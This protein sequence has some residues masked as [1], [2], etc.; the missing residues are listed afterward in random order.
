MRLTLCLVLWTMSFLLASNGSAPAQMANPVGVMVP[1][2]A[3]DPDVEKIEELTKAVESFRQR[4]NDQALEALK[5]ACKA[6]D[7]LPPARLMLARLHLAANQRPLARAN[8]EQAVVD[9]PSYPSTYFTLGALAIQE[10]RWTDAQLQFEKGAALAKGD[11]W[12]AGQKKFFQVQYHGGLSAVAEGRRDWPTVRTAL[13]AVLD[14]EPKNVRFRQGLARALVFLDKPEQALQE[15]DKAAK[16]DKN[17]QPTALIMGQF[18]IQKGDRKK[19]DEWLEKAVKDAPEDWRTH[20]G[21]ANWLLQQSKIEDAKGHA[22]TAGRLKADT[23]E[24]NLLRGVIARY[25][26]DYPLAEK[27]FQELHKQAPENFQARNQLA[28]A[29]AE[30]PDKEKRG[31][32]LQLAALNANANPSSVEALSTLGWVYYKL[33]RLDEAER[34]LTTA[35]S[36]GTMTAETAY[37]LA[38]VMSDRGRFDNAR[39]LLKAAVDAPGNFPHRKDAQD[40]L[41]RITKKP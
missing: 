41:E 27:Y 37:Y 10:T 17:P 21:L 8:L 20:V 19:A 9:S 40:W 32:A 22:E 35:A 11:Q 1:E 14:L 34:A 7:K 29:L 30:Q 28:L 38:H 6:H 24:L 2:L 5:A 31:Q 18:Y 3:G 15:L 39:A 12:T 26:K 16:E 23:K 33:E 25:Q 36:G 4:Q 13:A